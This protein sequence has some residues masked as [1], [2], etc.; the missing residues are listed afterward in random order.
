M[1]FLVRL[2]ILVL[3]LISIIFIP[4]TARSY[5]PKLQRFYH[6]D[7]YVSLIIDIS[8]LHGTKSII[9]LYGQSIEGKKIICLRA[10]C[11]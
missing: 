10:Q 11:V 3:V 5:E 1:T 8:K 6:N 7:E 2:K 9:F 4:N